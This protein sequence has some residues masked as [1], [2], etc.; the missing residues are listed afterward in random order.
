MEW[1]FRTEKYNLIRYGL[2]NDESILISFWGYAL[3]TAAFLLNRI[4]SKSVQKTPYEIWTRKPP[5][6]SF[7]K[8]LGYESYVKRHISNKLAPKSDKCLFVEYPKETKGY[9]FYN[10]LENKVFVA[11]NAIFFEREHISKGTSGSK[12]QLDEIRVPQRSIEP[13]METQQVSQDVVEPAQVPQDLRRSSR[14]HQNP[15]IYGFLVTDNHDVILMDHDEPASYQEAI[16]STDSDRWLEAIKSKMQSMYDN[17]VWTL[18]DPPNGLKTIGCK[19]VFTRR[20]TWMAM[21]IPLRHDWL[22]KVSRKHMV[23]TMMKLFHQ[24]LCISLLESY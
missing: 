8:I 12:I 17:Q 5:S 21:C 3:E 15:E 18:I 7:L 20:L 2:I 9:Y 19:W 23:F 6:L 13:V 10:S 4:P 1:C 22:Q 16:S 24:W 14:I 11:R